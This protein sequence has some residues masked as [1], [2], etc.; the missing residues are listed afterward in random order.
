MQNLALNSFQLFFSQVKS[1]PESLRIRVLQAIFDIMM[2]YEKEMMSG[3]ES[4]VSNVGHCLHD[5]RSLP[6]FLTGEQ[7]HSISH[8]DSRSR[9]V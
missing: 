6:V 2:T 3:E 9:G 1:S 7:S 4:V 5:N 8:A